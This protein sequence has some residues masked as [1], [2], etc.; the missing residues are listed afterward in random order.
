MKI[1]PNSISIILAVILLPFTS[2][3]AAPGPPPPQIVPPPPPGTP[4]DGGL[5]FLLILSLFFG[6]YKLKQ[7]HY[8]KKA[9]N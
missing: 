9:S 1:V 4:L 6:I 5:W 7:I 3:F 2:V 8:I